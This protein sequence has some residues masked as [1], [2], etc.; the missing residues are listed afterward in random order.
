[1][2]ANAYIHARIWHLTLETFSHPTIPLLIAMHDFTLRL[3]GGDNR[4]TT[5]KRSKT[6]K[7]KQ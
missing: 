2:K 4:K 3:S 7:P 5:I 1:M 6:N